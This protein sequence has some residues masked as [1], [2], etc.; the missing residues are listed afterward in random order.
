VSYRAFKTRDWVGR[1]EYPPSVRIQSGR[2]YVSWNGA[3][4]VDAWEIQGLEDE[5]EE[6]DATLFESLDVIEKVGFEAS[7]A[8]PEASRYRVAAF[9]PGRCSSRRFRRD[10]P[11]GFAFCAQVQLGVGGVSRYA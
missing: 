5:D 3:T 4:E 10:F 8:E 1:L 6:D 11:R 7:F 9:G 2:L